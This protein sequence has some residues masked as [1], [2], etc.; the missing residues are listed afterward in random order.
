MNTARTLLRGG[1]IYD[2]SAS[3]A[4]VGDILIEGTGLSDLLLL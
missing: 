4:F 2:G 1:K 3:E